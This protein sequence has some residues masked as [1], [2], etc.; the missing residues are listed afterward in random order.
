[1]IGCEG[2]Y[3]R[4]TVSISFTHRTTHVP[5]MDWSTLLEYCMTIF[6]LCN[7]CKNRLVP[8]GYI[9]G[10]FSAQQMLVSG[11][12]SQCPPDIRTCIYGM[13]LHILQHQF[14][15]RPCEGRHFARKI[16]G[17]RIGES[18]HDRGGRGILG[19]FLREEDT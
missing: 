18:I 1:M 14:K 19:H 13:G 12:Q 5:D 10:I 11:L 3:V 16:Y 15:L 8:W 4:R 17:G 2:H 7:T 9:H 6:C